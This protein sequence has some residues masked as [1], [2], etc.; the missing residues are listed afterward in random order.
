MSAPGPQQG[1]QWTIG[2]LRA[3]LVGLADD[4][5][6]VVDVPTGNGGARRYPI[7]GVGYGE[8]IDPAEGIFVGQEFPLVAADR[9]P[10]EGEDAHTEGA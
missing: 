2:Q 9:A 1:R 6:L 8:G 3:E 4:T 5:P 7:V 10:A